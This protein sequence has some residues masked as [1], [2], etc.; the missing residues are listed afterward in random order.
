M[1]ISKKITWH[2]PLNLVQ[3][4]I[5]NYQ[6][7]LVFLYSALWQKVDN[8]KSFLALFPIETMMLNNFSQLDVFLQN[9]QKTWFGYCSYENIIDLEKISLSNNF[10]I[11]TTPFF[12]QNFG[13]VLEFDH[14]K[15]KLL[16]KYQHQKYLDFILECC[17]SDLPPSLKNLPKAQNIITN[18]NKKQYLQAILDIQQKILAGDLFQTNLTQ[19]FYGLLNQN[20][21]HSSAFYLF[22]KLMQISPANYSSFAVFN[23]TFIISASPELFLEAKNQQVLSKPIKGTIA[24]KDNQQQDLEQQKILQNSSKDIAENLMI[25]DLMRNDLAKVCKAS[26]VLVPKLFELHSYKNLHHLVSSVSGKLAKKYNY[27]SLIKACFPP[28]SM[29]GAPKL[30]AIKVANQHEKQCRGIYSGCLGFIAKNRLNLAVVIRTLILQQNQF[31][32]Q[33]GGA[34]TYAS[35]PMQEFFEVEVKSSALHKLLS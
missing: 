20:I 27:G 23:E 35:D 26:S 16:I 7:N 12:W 6:Q 28:G 11:K 31:E 34:I 24:S 29:T 30:E 32:F 22:A 15:K 9:N 13:L 8:S 4:V 1:F 19:K 14:S 10:Y 2:D 21:N 3:K 25:T 5:A 18:L 33:A 17:K